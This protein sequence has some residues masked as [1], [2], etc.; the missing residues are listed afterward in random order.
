[1]TSD[2][3]PRVTADR[4]EEIRRHH[5]K[6]GMH[7]GTQSDADVGLLLGAYLEAVARAER[8]EAKPVIN[9]LLR[10]ELT[11]CQRELE[12]CNWDLRNTSG[13]ELGRRAVEVT[14]NALHATIRERD[15][16][17]FMKENLML[18]NIEMVKQN[19]ALKVEYKQ[20]MENAALNT[21]ALNYQAEVND[22]LKAKLESA[23]MATWNTEREDA[24][25]AKLEVCVEAL[26]KY[27]SMKATI[28]TLDGFEPIEWQKTPAGEA[29]AQLKE[30]K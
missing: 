4:I 9:H 17:Q 11:A 20:L 8:A 7:R 2:N 14:E 13:Y 23:I 5:N 28:K 12:K 30:I 26:E 10:V 22:A 19:E 21:D 6:P 3:K 18:A 29:L 16:L 24:L 25:K 15:A 1:M 27:C